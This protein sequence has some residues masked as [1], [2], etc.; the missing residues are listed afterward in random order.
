MPLLDDDSMPFHHDAFEQIVVDYVLCLMSGMLSETWALVFN[1]LLA[2]T[3]YNLL[4][5]DGC[6]SEC[7]D[8]CELTTTLCVAQLIFCN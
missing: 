6:E 1:K 8:Y 4:V 5:N 2:C 3:Q 7:S